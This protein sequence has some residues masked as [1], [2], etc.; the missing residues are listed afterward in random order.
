MKQITA[1]HVDDDPDS[2]N[3]FSDLVV[4]MPGLSLVK[5]FT[6]PED[7]LGY[8]QTNVVDVLF[9]DIEM[10][11]RNGFW[12][13]E[14]VPDPEMKVVFVTSHP[15]H[16]L[17]AFGAGAIDYL[18][19][20]IKPER[21]ESLLER[22]R[23][24]ADK[25]TADYQTGIFFDSRTGLAPYPKR[26]LVQAKKGIVHVVVLEDIIYFAARGPYA[27]V[28]LTSGK[29]LLSRNSIKSFTDTLIDHPSFVRTHRS[30]LV[31]RQHVRALGSDV[32]WF[33]LTMSNGNEIEG[34]Q[35]RKDEIIRKLTN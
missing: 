22:I 27:T 2:L 25:K 35:R 34:A 21:L 26:V 5:S 17:D 9:T 28:Y 14:Q 3:S 32:G 16:A 15:K 29:K 11:K 6:K 30:F 24:R 7:A 10:P 31:N 4:G 20:P 1:L 19:K 18:V 8:L 13:A 23:D 12:L 33:F